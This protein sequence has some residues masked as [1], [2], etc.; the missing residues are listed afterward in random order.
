MKSRKV[1]SS[2]ILLRRVRI[3]A[4][5]VRWRRGA[6]GGKAQSGRR[7]G[8]LGLRL[9]AGRLPHLKTNNQLKMKALEEIYTIYV[10]LHRSDLKTSAEKSPVNLRNKYVRFKRFT[11]FQSIFSARFTTGVLIFDDLYSEFRDTS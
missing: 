7:A 11:F 9:G 4:I 10:L 8:W 2:P 1:K 3:A 6:W 5:F